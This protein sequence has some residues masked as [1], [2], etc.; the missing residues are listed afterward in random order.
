[1]CQMTASASGASTAE[2]RLCS[3]APVGQR[4]IL[5]LDIDRSSVSAFRAA[6]ARLAVAKPA[7]TLPPN[8]VWLT[9][10]PLPRIT[11]AW[12]EVY[13]VYAALVPPRT[14]API[15]IL[16]AR[17]PAADR[18]LHPFSGDR[19]A[20]PVASERIPLGHYDIDNRAPFT[21]TFGLLQ[22]ATVNRTRV[23]SP[24]NVSTVAPS[25]GAD[26]VAVTTL[27]VW[28][29]APLETGSAAAQIPAYAALVSFTPD[30]PIKTYRYD[31][32]SSRFTPVP[33]A[34][35]RERKCQD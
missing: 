12:D 15:R 30:D 5:S 22:T 21:V 29:G 18:A 2:N 31:A 20:A 3:E 17:Y 11:I 32:A 35:G 6:G 8:V 27:Y 13:G 1:M 33:R 28:L 23:R 14:G 24:V 4:F 25:S 10:E 16:E 26:F 34:D 19:F 9:C 7:G